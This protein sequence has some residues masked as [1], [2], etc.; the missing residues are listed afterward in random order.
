MQLDARNVRGLAERGVAHDVHVREAGDAECIAEPTAAGTFKVG[1]EVE[2]PCDLKS[3]EQSFHA[4]CRIFGGGAKA[5]VPGVFCRESSVLLANEV[6]LERQPKA[7]PNRF[8][9]LRRQG[10]GVC[11]LCKR[12]GWKKNQNQQQQ[13]QR[14]PWLKALPGDVNESAGRAPRIHCFVTQRSN[15]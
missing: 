7:I 15:L 5:I 6:G 14:L 3:R 2:L 8:P 9:V 12:K 4:R 11:V 10:C 13:T 1:N